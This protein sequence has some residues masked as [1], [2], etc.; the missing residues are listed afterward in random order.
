MYMTRLTSNQNKWEKPSGE[1]GKCG[2]IKN[3]LMKGNLDL[4]GRN[5]F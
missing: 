2:L 4:V 3:R 1:N 5:G